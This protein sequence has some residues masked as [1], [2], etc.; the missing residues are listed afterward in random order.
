[1]VWFLDRIN[2]IYR[3]KKWEGAIVP[4]GRDGLIFPR[5]S[6]RK[7]NFLDRPR[8]Q[9]RSTNAVCPEGEGTESI[10][11][12]KRWEGQPLPCSPPARC[13]FRAIGDVLPSHFPVLRLAWLIF[14]PPSG[15]ELFGRGSHIE[16]SVGGATPSVFDIWVRRGR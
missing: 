5:K 13:A 8:A 2:R 10:Y 12:M 9:R 14:Q 3:M 6:E 16:S 4:R 1:M 15:V 7:G 11:R